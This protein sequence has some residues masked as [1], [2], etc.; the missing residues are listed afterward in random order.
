MKTKSLLFAV[1]LLLSALAVAQ[2][3]LDVNLLS[4]TFNGPI[5]TLEV[6]TAKGT[7]SNAIYMS[8][9]AGVSQALSIRTINAPGI[10]VDQ[11]SLNVYAVD[12]LAGGKTQDDR[13]NVSIQGH[14]A[15]YVNAHFTDESGAV[16]RR[17]ALIIILNPRTVIM[18]LQ[19]AAAEVNDGGVKDWETFTNSLV[20]NEKTCW[21]PEGCK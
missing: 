13:Q 17:R 6:P 15:V 12:V 9:N 20:I 7:S 2:N 4:A 1:V 21:L 16:A 11:A 8:G 5:K 3:T 10:A 14:I 18:I 19:Q